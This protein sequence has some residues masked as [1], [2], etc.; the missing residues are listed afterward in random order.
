[1]RA[2]AQTLASVH[3]GGAL[4]TAVHR[5]RGSDA[6]RSLARLTRALD[7]EPEATL[8]IVDDVHRL[9]EQGSLDVLAFLADRFPSQSRIAF[10]TRAD[11]ALPI[12]RWRLAGRVLLIDRTDLDFDAQECALFLTRLGVR[13]ASALA[14][15]VHRRTEGWVAGVHLMGLSLAQRPDDAAGG[16][17]G[18][19]MA[20]AEAHV[21]T[22]LLDQLDAS[23]RTMLVRTSYLDVVTAPLADAV[24]DEP[25]S[26]RRLADVAARG[27]LVTSLDAGTSYHY[28]ALL[29]ET[30]ARELALDPATELDV[31]V[32]AAAWYGAAG[33]PVE[34][35][36][37]A[38]GAGDL[39]RATAL[40]VEVAQALYRSGEV[41]SLLRWIGSF[42]DMALRERPELAAFAAFLYALEGD[43]P[44]ATRWAGIMTAP[45]SRDGATATASDDGG[46]GVDYVAAML[47]PRGPEVMLEDAL[48]ALDEHGQ[49][50]SWRSNALFA[51]G[52]ASWMLGQPALAVERFGEIERLHG[53]DAALVRL[54]VRAERAIAEAAQ[55]RWGSVQAILDLDRRSVLDD[56]E[57]GRIAGLLWL[58]AD[59]RLAIH[60]GDLQGA[61]DR[62][63]RIQV[64]RVRLSWAL[65]WYS[66]RT[67][68]ELARAQLLVGDH[69]GA[70]VTL[71][72]ARD[73][74]AVRPRL[75][76]LIDEL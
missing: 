59:A 37:H 28:H 25:G 36:E 49:D 35:I 46:P 19:A 54:A 31:R 40:I 13:E 14:P 72:Q 47:C 43:A 24:C 1:M 15:L 45:V 7:A 18:S 9:S 73:T 41:A 8:L 42:E 5:A 68:T 38:L 64:G 2:L 23:T 74:V 33:M 48:R 66:V 76:I 55:R 21:R 3:P 39:D 52:M 58:V 65:P 75:G 27:L 62:L 10:G 56:P 67:L 20:E 53:I 61:N 17:G 4:A 16:V 22:E 30:L 63:Q 26:E 69:R 34:A 50:W 60:H 12:T 6:L 57:S 51:A 71:S 44:A 70:R 11:P 32:R 29:R